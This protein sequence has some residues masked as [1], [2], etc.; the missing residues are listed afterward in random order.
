MLVVET[1]AA[2]EH[3][4]YKFSM[5]DQFSEFMAAGTAE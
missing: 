1:A 3:H 4:V 5:D 2:T